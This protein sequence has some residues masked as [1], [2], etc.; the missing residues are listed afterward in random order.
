MAR[1][2]AVAG[3][4]LSVGK[5]RTAT[6]AG[7]RLIPLTDDALMGVVTR[8]GAVFQ[9]PARRSGADERLRAVNTDVNMTGAAQLRCCRIGDVVLTAFRAATARQDIWENAVREQVGMCAGEGYVSLAMTRDAQRFQVVEL[10]GFPVVGEQSERH[11][12]IDGQFSFGRSAVAASVVVA[13][14][15]C[16][17][18]TFPVWPASVCSCHA[19]IVPLVAN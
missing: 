10:V 3:R 9:R 17:P 2:R 5:H 12:V 6:D 15:C 19:N 14:P 11:D 1:L 13:Q 7:T 8:S 4:L 18:L 16:S